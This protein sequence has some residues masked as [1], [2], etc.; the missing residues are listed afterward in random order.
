[1]RINLPNQITLGRLVLAV[2]FFSL[3]NTWTPVQSDSNRLVMTI[4]FWLF[5]AAVLGDILDGY[6]ARA[7][8]Q[9]TSFGRIVDPVVDK[10]LICGAFIYF[11]SDLFHDPVSRTNLTGTAPW[12]VVVILIRELLVSAV[13]SHAES[14][15]H[16]LPANWAGKVKMFVQSTTICVVLGTLA[17]HRDK[18]GMMY[19]AHSCV[20]I[21]VVVTML[22]IITYLRRAY[23]FL[24]SA[25][26]LAG[27]AVTR[28]ARPASRAQEQS[29][30]TRSSA[31]KPGEAV[32]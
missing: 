31:T 26:A 27:T 17:W 8:Q 19:F 16:E 23:S 18:P 12:M 20:W 13:R 15:G 4:C 1:M 11:A 29:G 7:M 5:L 32:A 2:V 9:V 28:D 6:L 22:S 21:T 14:H 10:V 25:Q 3:L 24:L 30:P